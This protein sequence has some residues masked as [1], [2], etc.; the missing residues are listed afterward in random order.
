[1]NQEEFFDEQIIDMINQAEENTSDSMS[2]VQKEDVSQIEK[3][4]EK[5][6]EKEAETSKINAGVKIQGK[7]IEFEKRSLANNTISMMVPKNF[8]PMSMEKVRLKYPS[9]HRPETIL[10]NDLG[11]INIM[12]QYMDGEV[13][14]STIEVFR[15]QIFGTMKR[16]NPGIKERTIGTVQAQGMQIAYVEFSNNTWDGKLYNCMFYLAIEEKPLMGSFNCP[17]KEMKYWKD[18]AIEMMQ[19]I[20]IIEQEKS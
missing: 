13:S 1:M 5:E 8:E 17:T 15:N 10:T 2:K 9:E 19:S 18:L 20:E 6:A 14:N 12:F 11:T 3:Q 4:V 16:V 7:W